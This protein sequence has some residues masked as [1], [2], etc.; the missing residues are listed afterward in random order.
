MLI[1]TKIT[2]A[3]QR[4][5]YPQRAREPITPPVVILSDLAGIQSYHFIRLSIL[6]LSSSL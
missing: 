3:T 4:M 5:S 1:I 6:G 2:H